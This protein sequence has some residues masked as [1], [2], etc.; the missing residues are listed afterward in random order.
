MS[1][2][3]LF[4][5]TRCIGC[6]AC[7]AACKDENHLPVNIDAELN[8]YTWTTVRPVAGTS[9]VFV[10][11]LCMHC[12]TPTCVS[13]CPV[14]ALY[15]TPEGAV[16]Y[17]ADK[18]IGCRYCIMACPFDVPKYQWDRAVPIVGK[19]VLCTTRV[20]S[21]QPTACA[22]VCPT[23]ATQF[24]E[25]DDLLRE[26]HARIAGDPGKYVDHVYGEDEA[27]GTSV[28]L[29]SPVPFERLGYR[30]TLPRH[31]PPMITWQILSKVPDFVGL[32]ASGLFG[33]HWITHRREAVRAAAHAAKVPARPSRLRRLW[34]RLHGGPS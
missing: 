6:Q 20:K 32:A 22:E 26:A 9:D 19:C 31:A 15:K 27:G 23:G 14:A 28:L 4:D 11:R 16:A 30:T 12:L 1:V 2:G 24:G 13:V 8:A 5:A 29:V 10:R 7:A 33:L 3:L 17:D 21:G 34:T 18:C 25:R